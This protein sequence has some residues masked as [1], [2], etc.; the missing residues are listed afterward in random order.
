MIKKSLKKDIFIALCGPAFVGKGFVKNYLKKKFGFKEPPVYTTRKKRKN[1]NTNERIFLNE[2]KF[3]KKI[4]EGELILPHKI[5]GNYYAFPKDAF[6]SSKYQITEIHVKNLL[7]FR[8]ILPSALVI[9][10]LP[11]DINFLFKRAER[12]KKGSKENEKEI[13]LRLRSAKKE[14]KKIL[15]LKEYLNY[16]YYVNKRN[17]NLICKQIEDYIKNFFNL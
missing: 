3:Q 12:R 13:Q 7:K 17:E 5:Y 14:I 11:K 9:A 4:K 6:D 10:I 2:E 1:E 16:I 15:Q 8:K